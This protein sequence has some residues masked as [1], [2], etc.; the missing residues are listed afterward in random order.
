VG[1]GSDAG[2]NGGDRNVRRRSAGEGSVLTV[3][4]GGPDGFRIRGV[5]FLPARVAYLRLAVLE[6]LGID[7]AQG[8]VLVV[9]TVEG[10]LAGALDELGF[11]AAAFDPGDDARR[12]PYGDGAFDVA[13]YHD[14]F[15]ITEDLG[16]VVREAARVLRPQGVLVY[17]TVNRTALSRL[18]YLGALQSWRWTRI[19][20]RSR[21]APECLRPPEELAAALR[22]QG[23]HNQDVRALVP[24]SPLRLFRS[25]LRAKRGEIADDELVRLAGMHVA[26][27]G[28]RPDVTYLGFARKE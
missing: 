11:S 1:A 28:K 6:R 25:L 23:L 22:A 8:E 26:D 13:Y 19:M 9:G 14:T 10:G 5:A 21:Y 7:P 20:P 4:A 16:D 24:A 27:S 12:L 17:D 18:I 3:R 15:E 2:D